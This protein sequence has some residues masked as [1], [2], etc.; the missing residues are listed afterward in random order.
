[1]IGKLIAS[2]VRVVIGFSVMGGT[3]GALAGPAG[4]VAGATIAGTGAAVVMGGIVILASISQVIE[5][6]KDT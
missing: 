3:A 6:K 4:I 2:S 1:M 5:K